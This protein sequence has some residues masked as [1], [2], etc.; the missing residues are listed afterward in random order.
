[1][2]SFSNLISNAA[3]SSLAAFSKTN[4]N[5]INE[6]EERAST[7]LIIGLRTIQLQK[8]ILVTG[9]FAM[10]DAE[11]QSRLNCKNGFKEIVGLLKHQGE[12]NLHQ[13]FNHFR[14]AVNVLKHGKGRSYE[15]LLENIEE[16]PFNIKKPDQN[17]F[18]EGDV[19]EVSTLIQVDDKFVLNAVQVICE[20]SEW[21]NKKY[22]MNA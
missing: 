9:I 2:H 4:V 14:N 3:K 19:S 22:N 17:F 12:E 7:S 5:I 18:D 10:F 1:M 6:L 21:I 11:L 20:I 16:L 13:N 8:A 15:A